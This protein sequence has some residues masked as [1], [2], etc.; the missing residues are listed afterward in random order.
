MK[1]IEEIYK[2]AWD[3]ALYKADGKIV[4]TVMFYGQIDYP[5]SFF[6]RNDELNHDLSTL[7]HL[8]DKIRNNY[9]AYL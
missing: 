8:S 4:I 2:S 6:V 1:S 3:Y 7:K 5:R 9:D